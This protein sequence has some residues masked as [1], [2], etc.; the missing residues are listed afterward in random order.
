MPLKCCC[1]ASSFFSPLLVDLYNISGLAL[2]RHSVPPQVR[3]AAAAASDAAQ[4]PPVSTPPLTDDAAEVK[5]GPWLHWS[6]ARCN[7]PDCMRLREP[8]RTC[9]GR[10]YQMRPTDHTRICESVYPPNRVD[11]SALHARLTQ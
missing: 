2:L 9:A 11:P 3:T 10:A 7:R 6:D 1:F 8:K 4:R 5:N